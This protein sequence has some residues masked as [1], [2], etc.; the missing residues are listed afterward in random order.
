MGKSMKKAN[1]NGIVHHLV[2]IILLVLVAGGVGFAGWR[3]YQNKKMVASA[4]TYLAVARTNGGST[5]SVCSIGGT[6]WLRFN[7]K[8]SASDV[9]NYGGGVGIGYA[10]K[11][12]YFS[13]FTSLVRTDVGYTW[14]PTKI[15]AAYFLRSSTATPA[16]GAEKLYALNGAK[17]FSNS[18]NSSA[19][20]ISGYDLVVINSVKHSQIGSC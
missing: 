13:R 7:F 20:T 9:N 6:G 15:E 12:A 18:T 11:K 5:I 8:R 16:A 1:E 14:S 19:N 10:T 17:V 4:A 2:L 3:V